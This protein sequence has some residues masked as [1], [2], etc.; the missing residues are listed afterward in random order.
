MQSTPFMWDHCSELYYSS[1]HRYLLGSSFIDCLAGYHW[2]SVKPWRTVWYTMFVLDY[3][4]LQWMKHN[5]VR[6]I[7]RYLGIL[8]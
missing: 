1:L 4:L 6:F 2:G 3:A 8:I 7:L 5:T